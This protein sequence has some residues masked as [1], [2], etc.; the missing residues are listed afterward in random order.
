MRWSDYSNG[1]RIKILRGKQLSQQELANQTGLSMPTIRAAEQDRRM[2]LSTLVKIANALG[3]DAS[4]ILGQQ[5]PRRAMETDD[6]KTLRAISLCVHED[7]RRVP[8]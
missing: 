3:V 2:S 4:I 1:Q 6:R 7:G 8:S 5:A